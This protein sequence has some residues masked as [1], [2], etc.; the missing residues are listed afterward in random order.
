VL[1]CRCFTSCFPPPCP[2]RWT[3]CTNSCASPHFVNYFILSC[4]CSALR[5]PHRGWA[6]RWALWALLIAAT[7]ACSDEYHQSFEAGRGHPRWTRF[8]TTG[9]GTAQISIWLFFKMSQ[10]PAEADT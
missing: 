5:A 9:A 3:S 7:Y 8:D 2:P 6:R 10:Q 1:S 4:C